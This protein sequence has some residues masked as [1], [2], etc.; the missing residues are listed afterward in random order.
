M[1]I[2]RNAAACMRLRFAV[3]GQTMRI[4]ITHSALPADD[5][6]D[7]FSQAAQ[8]GVE[9]IEID[10]PSAGLAAALNHPQHAEQLRGSAGSSGID[11]AGLRLSFLR[12]EPSLIGRPETVER[13]SDMVIRAL[14]CA[15]EAG[16]SM[17]VLPFFG[18]NTIEIEQEL[19]RATDALTDL[20]DHAEQS[21]VCLVV[22]ST[23]PFHQQDFLLSH[24]GRTGEVRVCCNTAVATA[25]KL[26]APTGLRKLR[27]DDLALVRFK[28]VRIVEGAQPDYDVAFGEGNV[29]FRAAAQ[30]LRVM[31]YDGWAMIDPPLVDGRPSLGAAETA[32]AFVRAL[33]DG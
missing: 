18:K 20:L 21:G 2:D 32:L 14:G 4:G 11:L 7:A 30:A 6:A 8:L 26:D 24:L 31:G 17:I 27:V 25:R 28:D 19:S 23:L 3:S 33:L 15:A 29:D 9:G 1:T 16:A 12:D 10:Y 13:N 22:E 5:L